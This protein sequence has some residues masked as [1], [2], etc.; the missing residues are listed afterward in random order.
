MNGLCYLPARVL[1]ERLRRRELTATE[2]LD[3]HL[4]RIEK[5][6]PAL[7]AVVSMDDDLASQWC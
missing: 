3:A 5:Y 2:L 6:N 7:G 1:A 4:A